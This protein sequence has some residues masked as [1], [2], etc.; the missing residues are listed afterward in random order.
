MKFL[1]CK[2]EIL[3]KIF[4]K[5]QI[6]VRNIFGDMI[7]GSQLF[8]EAPQFN[9]NRSSQHLHNNLFSTKVQ[10]LKFLECETKILRKIF[11]KFQSLVRNIFGDMICASQVIS[12]AP[13]FNLNRSSQ[14]FRNKIFYTKVQKLK[15]LE[16]KAEI[17]RNIV[18]NS[19]YWFAIVSEI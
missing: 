8:L 12:Q 14:Y 18:K 6:L 4:K 16:C 13:E 7:F 11:T 17:L 2:A 9:L 19:R 1:E 5:I 3:R 10:N 15:F